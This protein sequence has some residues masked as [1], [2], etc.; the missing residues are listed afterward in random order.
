MAD[1]GVR[2]LDAGF[3]AKRQSSSGFVS[4]SSAGY[5]APELLHGGPSNATDVYSIGAM[6]Y[7]LLMGRAF[8]SAAANPER[9]ETKVERASAKLSDKVG[10][11]VAGLITDMLAYD[12]GMRVLPNGVIGIATR[13]A[14]SAPGASLA[15]WGAQL[16]GTVEARRAKAVEQLGGL[17]SHLVGEEGDLGSQAERDAIAAEAAR[18]AEEAARKTEE[19][20]QA[21]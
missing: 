7:M 13:L 14:D 12:P 1:G 21:A 2:I 5:T 3:R 11:A 15:E 18:K 9:H 20:R 8:G 17:V 19:A 10:H 4:L 6:A 16:V